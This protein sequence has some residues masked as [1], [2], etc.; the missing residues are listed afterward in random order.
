M[1]KRLMCRNIR[2]LHHFEP[3]STPDEIRAAA[4]QFV[5]KVSGLNKPASADETAFQK[6]ID[7][8]A[9]DAG[10]AT[11]DAN[12]V[13]AFYHRVAPGVDSQF[14]GPAMLPLIA[15]RPLLAINGD[16]DPRTPR[17][18]LMECAAAAAQAYAAAGA[19]DRFELHLQK[20]TAHQ[21]RPE[22]LDLAV[23]WFVKWLRPASGPAP[24]QGSTHG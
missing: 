11:I 8:A 24:G 20:D 6:A 5:R 19:R 13:R 4:L 17:P 3:P 10:V 9:Q 12:F 14:D 21:V 2:V 16:S 7:G 1:L 15:P 22:A 23:A 18:G